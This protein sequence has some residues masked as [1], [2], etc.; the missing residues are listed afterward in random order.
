MRKMIED[1]AVGDPKMVWCLE[2]RGPFLEKRPNWILFQD[3]AGGVF[4]EKTCHHFDLVT[5][6][7]DSTPKKVIALA[8]QDAVKDLYGVQP[9]IFDNGWVTI[10]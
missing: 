4:V 7:A 6:F 5:W 8:G 1:N 3:K 10:E 9:D 2:F